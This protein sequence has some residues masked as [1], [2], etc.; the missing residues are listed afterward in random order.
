MRPIAVIAAT[1]LLLAACSGS[2]SACA[3]IADDAIGVFQEVV[4]AVDDLDL[5]ESGAGADF[6]IPG[7][8]AIEEKA[9]RLQSDADAAGCSD[10]ELRDLLT[11]RL[12]RLEAR[13]VFGQAVIEAI[14]QEGLFGEGLFGE[15]SG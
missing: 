2:G 11:E 7:M 14:R 1:S 5:A 15:G 4:T 10:E 8:P 3:D 13:T 6:E 9:A 12:V